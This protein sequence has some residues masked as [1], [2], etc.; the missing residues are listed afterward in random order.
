LGA[1]FRQENSLQDFTLNPI[2]FEPGTSRPNEEGAE[3]LARLKLFLSQ[4]PEVDLRLS[5]SSGAEDM[6]IRQDQMILARLQS[7]LPHASPSEAAAVEQEPLLADAP[8]EEVRK[9][10]THRLSRTGEEPPLPLSAQAAAL[11]A[12]LRK[13]TVLDPQE[14]QQLA[15]E[16][17][18][19]VIAALTEG[20]L[21]SAE[22]LH[23][24]PKRVRGRNEAEVQYVIEAREARPEKARERAAA[25]GANNA[26]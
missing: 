1:L 17:M 16:R 19:T 3:Q 2:A 23:L 25:H 10:L 18:H 14:L 22:R 8:S 13:A 15:Q 21:V 24:S 9:F 11:L 7:D 6:L 20:T 12:Q 4:R 26:P 5:G